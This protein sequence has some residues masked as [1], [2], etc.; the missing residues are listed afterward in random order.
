[1]TLEVREDSTLILNHFG[2][3]IKLECA[4]KYWPEDPNGNPSSSQF[5]NAKN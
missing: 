5:H 4:F 2:K 3:T 1:M